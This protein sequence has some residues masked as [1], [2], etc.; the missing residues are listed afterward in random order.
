M[1]RFMIIS[2][3]FLFVFVS[4]GMAQSRFQLGLNFSPMFPQGGFKDQLDRMGWGGSMNFTYRIPRSILSVGASIGYYIYGY[5]SRFEPLSTTIPDMMVKVSTTNA[6]VT[7]H[8]YLR[9][10]PLRGPLRPYLDCLLGFQHLTTDTRVRMSYN[11]DDGY[12][13]SNQWN[14]TVLSYGFGGGLM[15]ALTRQRAYSAPG[16]FRIA[17]DMGFKYLR[18]GVAEYLTEGAIEIIEDEVFYYVSESR[19]D[20]VTARLGVIFS[21]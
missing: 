12:P 3:L 21:F 6:V 10:Q 4:L 18:G 19:T 17:L 11:Y 9:L 7:G 1:K 15:I 16:R 2:V 20:I 5:Q 13:R 8:A 14:D